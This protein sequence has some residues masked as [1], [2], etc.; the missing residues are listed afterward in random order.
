MRSRIWVVIDSMMLLA[1]VSLQAWRLTGVVLHEWLALA[2]IAGIVLHLLLHWSWVQSRSRRIFLPRTGRTRV[3]YALNLTLFV[4]MSAAMFSGF[5]ISKVVLPGH[6]TPMEYLKWHGI[7]DF[8]SRV[9]LIVAGLHLGLNWDLMSLA[10][11]NLLRRREAV[12]PATRRLRGGLAVRA[13]VTIAAT[14]AVIGAALLGVERVLPRK[15]VMIILPGGKRIE[16]AP[17]PADIARLR[18]DEIPPSSRGIPPAIM[19][20]VIVALAAVT[21]RKVLR[22]RLE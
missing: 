3:N 4:A 18:P 10:F 15:D 16:H 1:V 20:G 21:A 17:P 19:Q 2:L 8:S 9:V 12:R 7:H 6:L 14:V 13:I 22:L 11:R 5:M